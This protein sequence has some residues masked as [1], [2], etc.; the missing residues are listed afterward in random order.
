MQ[1]AVIHH[2]VDQ[3]PQPRLAER[4]LHLSLLRGIPHHVDLHCKPC[5]FVSIVRKY[6]VAGKTAKYVLCC[7]IQLQIISS[8]SN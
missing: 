1:P 7:I 2:L 3:E 5:C 8:T 6:F 4:Y